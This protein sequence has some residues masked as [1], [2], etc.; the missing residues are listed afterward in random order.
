M[1]VLLC[2]LSHSTILG[3]DF[4]PQDPRGP[5]SNVTLKKW[6][7]KVYQDVAIGLWPEKKQ[8]KE[9]R[10]WQERQKQLQR[11]MAVRLI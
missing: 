10:L 7:S 1:S 11:H 8:E 5:V 3:D 4:R 6:A 2:D 9:Q